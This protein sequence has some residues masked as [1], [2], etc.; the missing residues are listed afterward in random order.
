MMNKK[1]SGKSR[2][3]MCSFLAFTFALVTVKG[4]AQDK[5]L[6]DPMKP[7][8]FAL[9]KF[10]QAKR[11]KNPP[12][13]TQP[14]ITRPV[15]KSLQLTSVIFSKHRKVAVIGDQLLTLGE[16]I[17]DAKLVEIKP[18]SVRLLRKGK[19]INLRLKNDL[20]AIVK[21]AVESDL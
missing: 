6:F 16:K 11:A 18:D 9:E 17:G 15:E 13:A 7:P 4:I 20:T 8:P 1:I 14:A 19:V 2:I 12:V 5:Q 21:R 3:L 10:R